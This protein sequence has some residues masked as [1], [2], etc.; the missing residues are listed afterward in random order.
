[1]IEQGLLENPQPLEDFADYY[2]GLKIKES[3]EFKIGEAIIKADKTSF[4]LGYLKLP[5][6]IFKINS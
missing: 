2:E 6:D 4:K 1:M 5:F 3:K